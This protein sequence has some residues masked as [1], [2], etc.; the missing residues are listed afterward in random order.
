M[1]G[2]DGV[3]VIGTLNLDAFFETFGLLLGR[4]YGVELNL[5][6]RE[7]AEEW[8]VVVHRVQHPKEQRE[9]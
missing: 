9:A 5:R 2:M 8:S 3:K 1:D 6:S 4:R 7:S